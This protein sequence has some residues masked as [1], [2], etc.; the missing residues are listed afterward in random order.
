MEQQHGDLMLPVLLV[1]PG[2]AEVAVLAMSLVRRGKGRL[3]PSI[4]G[5]LDSL[6]ETLEPK[7]HTLL[8]SLLPWFQADT[9]YIASYELPPKG[10]DLP[11]DPSV[12]GCS[13]LLAVLLAMYALGGDATLW[14]RK[15]FRK[16]LEGWT[17]SSFPDKQGMLQ[18][19]ELLREKLA[20]AFRR[21]PFLR[22]DKKCAPISNVLLAEGDKA[23]IA[24][25]LGVSES[26]IGRRIALSRDQVLDERVPGAGSPS[27]VITVHFAKDFREA[28]ETVF[29]A[30][31]V[32]RYRRATRYRKLAWCGILLAAVTLL[33]AL[34]NSA[35]P[36]IPPVDV[37]IEEGNRL[38]AVDHRGRVVWRRNLG[39][40][41]LVKR[42]FTDRH[43]KAR[44]MATLYT[45][46]DDAGCLLIFNQ[47]GHLLKRFDPGQTS[48]YTRA[49][50][51]RHITM[52]DTIEVLDSPGK[53][54][55]AI[56][57]S[58]KWPSRICVLSED[59]EVLREFW[60]PG[61]VNGFLR[62]GNTSKLFLWGPSND[63]PDLRDDEPEAE[64]YFAVYCIDLTE[65]SGQLPPYTAWI[66]PVPPRRE[67][68]WYQALIPKGRG[69]DKVGL[70]KDEETGRM[71]IEVGTHKGWTLY[72]KPDGAWCTARHDTHELPPT[73]LIDVLE[74]LKAR[75]AR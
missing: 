10:S 23:S 45:E 62:I 47:W 48:P 65:P 44:V 52:L 28:L 41:I 4:K 27:E 5:P 19:V 53:E 21:N 40:R 15:P 1:R 49:L 24:E 60:H 61:V 54:I 73:E 69:I 13:H 20:A 58:G 51:D 25:L 35:E 2:R 18:P 22:E 3:H 29:G 43:G 14:S 64:Y 9:D 7:S 17:A 8:A 33:V 67:P 75:E 32:S 59:G 30:D 70:R 38:V 37:K 36:R 50:H 16:K 74:V 68:L 72:I 55:L 71:E 31:L 26:Q 12:D 46:G 42:L 63:L 11:G 34:T 6:D 39:A 57:I 66:R 56:G